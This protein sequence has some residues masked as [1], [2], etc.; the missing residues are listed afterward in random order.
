MYRMNP[1][2]PNIICKAV[3]MNDKIIANIPAKMPMMIAKTTTYI[4]LLNNNFQA[5][6]GPLLV[7]FQPIENLVSVGK[8]LW[9][10]CTNIVL[11]IKIPM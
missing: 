7:M 2:I 11:V 1:K 8:D 9:S 5:L 10:I 3:G 6:C 4:I